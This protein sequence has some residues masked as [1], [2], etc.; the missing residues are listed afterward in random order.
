[1]AGRSP[2][3]WTSTTLPRI[4]T[5]VPVVIGLAFYQFD[6][7]NQYGVYPVWSGRNDREG[8]GDLPVRYQLVV[9]RPLRWTPDGHRRIIGQDAGPLSTISRIR[10]ANVHSL[11][12]I[13]LG[14][15]EAPPQN[16]SVGT[17]LTITIMLAGRTN[18]A[19]QDNCLD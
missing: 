9:I 4:E 18:K 7:L 8:D 2:S 5:T 1:M 10:I 13:K 14:T 11:F 17:C 19:Y 15:T 6:P 3:K 12:R 16:L